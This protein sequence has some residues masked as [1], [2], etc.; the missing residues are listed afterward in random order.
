[1]GF[2][3][4]QKHRAQGLRAV[5]S[6]HPW[7]FVEEVSGFFFVLLGDKSGWGGVLVCA[8]WR[9][10]CCVGVVCG[11]A[12]ALP[13]LLVVGVLGVVR[14]VEV[15]L[16]FWVVFCMVVGWWCSWLGIVPVLL[17]LRIL[18]LLGLFFGS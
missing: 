6:G 10:G 11:C 7:H 5:Y 9:G 3:G 18:L 14:V 13:A 4:S 17:V 1:M 2:Q 15:A 16:V 8:G 12:V